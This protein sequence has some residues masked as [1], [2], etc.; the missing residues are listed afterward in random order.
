MVRGR[1]G[2]VALAGALAIVGTIAQPARAQTKLIKPA[3]G[4]PVKITKSGSYILDANL[5]VGVILPDAIKV[6]ISNVSINLNGFGIIGPGAGSGMGV[7]AVG[8]NNVTVTNG[9]I[10][11]MGGAG[12]SLGNNGTV[13]NV[14]VISDGVGASGGDAVDCGTGCLIS[15]SV[16]AG[17]AN[18]DAINV[19]DATSGYL[20]NIINGN[21]AT[22]VGGTNMGG[23]ICNGSATCP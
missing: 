1:F 21:L 3:A 23:N 10:T 19:I 15:G 18:G 4:F 2:V 9:T 13:Q 7:D 6:S 11:A 14:R 8:M 16:L 20:N 5:L 17:N 22:V 12:I